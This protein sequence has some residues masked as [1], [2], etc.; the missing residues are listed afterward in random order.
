LPF[1]RRRGGGLSFWRPSTGLFFSMASSTPWL[2]RISDIFP[3]K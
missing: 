1:F 2:S 3:L